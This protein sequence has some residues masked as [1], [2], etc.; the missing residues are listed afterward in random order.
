[1]LLI[2]VLKI[3][4]YLELMLAVQVFVNILKNFDDDGTDSIKRQKY[5]VTICDLLS[6]WLKCH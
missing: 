2:M 5:W 1:M 4:Q 3:L 6:G